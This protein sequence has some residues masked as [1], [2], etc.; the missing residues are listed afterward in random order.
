M[1]GA[2]TLQTGEFNLASEYAERA[3]QL[4][5]C[6]RDRLDVFTRDLDRPVLN[7]NDIVAELQEYLAYSRDPQVRVI[8]IDSKVAVQDGHRWIDL[9]QQRP[10]ALQLRNPAKQHAD[11]VGAFCV[12]DRRHAIYR[13]FGDRWAGRCHADDPQYARRLNEFFDEAWEHGEPDPHTR[14]LGL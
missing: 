1:R 14:R 13:D 2:A 8:V 5:R 3:V 7:R 4:L 6:C 11:F 12:A 10:T 9:A